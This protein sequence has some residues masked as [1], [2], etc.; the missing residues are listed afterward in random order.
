MSLIQKVKDKVSGKLPLLAA[1]GAMCMTMCA[2]A[3]GI[4]SATEVGN[5]TAGAAMFFGYSLLTWIFGILAALLA[6]GALWLRD[7]RVI[8]ACIVMAILAIVT[9]Y[10]VI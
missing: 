8:I 7:F 1:A 6:V 2:V 4:V 5:E 10:Y 3:T 9:G